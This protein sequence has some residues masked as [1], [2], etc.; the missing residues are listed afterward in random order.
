MRPPEGQTPPIVENWWQPLDEPECPPGWRT[1]P[2]DFVGIGAQR[3]GTSWWYAGAIRSHPQVEE[4]EGRA[5][6]LHFF[7]RYWAEDPPADYAERYARFFPRPEGAITGEWT[8]RYLPDPWALPLLAKAAPEARILIMLR[9]PIARYRSAI[10]QGIERQRKQG[11]YPP[12]IALVGEAIGRSTYHDKVHRALEIF[13]RE[14]VLML[15]FER[16][17]AEPLAEMQRTHRFLGIEP[18][19]DLTPRL[20]RRLSREDRAGS[21]NPD[22]PTTLREELKELLAEDVRRLAQL[23]PEIDPGLWPNFAAR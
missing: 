22:L 13:G 23:C 21:E 20:E 19:N 6:E 18:L 8:P 10:A 15:Q 1:G 7:D 3:C 16:C 4:P 5:K 9:D 2:P 14:R 12:T 17:V 11:Q